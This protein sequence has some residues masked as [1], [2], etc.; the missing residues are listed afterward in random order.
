MPLYDLSAFGILKI[1]GPD[2]KKLLQGQCTCNLDEIHP[3]KGV[4]G[5]HCNPQG[6][7]IS[8]FYLFLLND[9]YYLVMPKSMLEI[10]ANALKK[11]ALF[12]KVVIEQT[13]EIKTIG[14]HSETLSVENSASFYLQDGRALLLVPQDKLQQL[15][16]A[17]MLDNTAW[18]AADIENLVPAIYPE[19]SGKFLPHEID[20]P[21]LHAVSF[22]KGCYTGQEIIARMHY[23][24]KLKTH[25]F[26]ATLENDT[27]PPLA[28]MLYYKQDHLLRAA[29]SIVD[30]IQKGYNS[31]QVLLITD[32]A[33]AK[34]KHLFL[35]ENNL[36]LMF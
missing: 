24:G 26:K 10:A 4:M 14:L 19:T 16:D 9:T 22:E 6:R 21:K 33:N 18:R 35:H 3:G 28:S 15:N 8:L 25:L 34:N 32:E 20:L 13:D 1:S 31:Y 2:A 30:V 36:F 5:A 7:V 23:R 27:L 29:G 17:L 11:Y 12:Y